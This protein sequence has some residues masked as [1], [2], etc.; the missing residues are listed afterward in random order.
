MKPR[1]LLFFL[2]LIFVAVVSATAQKAANLEV[3]KKLDIFPKPVLVWKKYEQN[4]QGYLE[5]P[6]A[7]EAVTFGISNWKSYSDDFFAASP[8]LPACET[9]KSASRTYVSIYD[10]DTDQYLYNWCGLIKAENIETKTFYNYAKQK[11][12]R[13]IYVTLEDRKTGKKVVSNPITVKDASL[14]KP[15]LNPKI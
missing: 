8:E 11:L 7:K 10:F 5:T 9:N 12:P 3:K 6:L 14:C 2:C 13:C 15:M 1:K 4:V